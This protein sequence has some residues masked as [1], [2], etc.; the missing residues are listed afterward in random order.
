MN[1]EMGGGGVRSL[2]SSSD[3]PVCQQN[4][5]HHYRF[6]KVF[7]LVIKCITLCRVVSSYDALCKPIYYKPILW[8]P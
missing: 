3:N 4:T 6:T 1:G 7:F 5:L 8:G 2:N